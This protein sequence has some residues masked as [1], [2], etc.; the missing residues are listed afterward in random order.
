MATSTIKHKKSSYVTCVTEDL[1][2]STKKKLLEKDTAFL[3]ENHIPKFEK[4]NSKVDFKL[5]EFNAR[6]DELEQSVTEHG[7]KWHQ[8]IEKI[9]EKNNEDIAK[10]RENGIR[11][12][13][14]YQ[15][16]IRK[17][18]ASIHEIILQ[19]NMIAESMNVR[20]ITEY[21]S[22]IQKYLR[23]SLDIELE[24]PTFVSKD[25]DESKM[26]KKF[27]KLKELKIQGDP[28]HTSESAN[29]LLDN[30][31]QIATFSTGITELMRI[32]C[33]DTDNAWVTKK[34]KPTITRVNIQGFVKETVTATFWD[35]PT[36]NSISKEEHLLYSDKLNRVVKDNQ[37]TKPRT[38]APQGW[39]PL[40]HNQVIC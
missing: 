20:D 38:T 34:N 26:Y 1:P 31:Y 7:E 3:K 9:V 29:D 27:G 18:L 35:H 25:I 8:F 39:V 12:L 15:R 36:D 32:A 19:N 33:Q 30:P 14:E 21:E 28:I 11:R 4:A 13:K 6:C 40:G 37:K 23:I 24:L 22:N 2:S 17:L 5:A 10:M 16:E